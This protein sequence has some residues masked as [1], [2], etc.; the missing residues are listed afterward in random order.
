MTDDTLTAAVARLRDRWEFAAGCECSLCR[1]IH[2]VL[3]ALEAAQA[4]AARYRWL[5][6]NM[7]HYNVD[8]DYDVEGRNVPALAQVSDRI[9]YHATDDMSDTLDAAI[10]AAM[11]G[12][13]D[14]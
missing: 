6:C 14:A 12:E 8:A 2:T 3:A 11:K 1:D 9:W 10:D 13:E 4:D 7:S 5:R